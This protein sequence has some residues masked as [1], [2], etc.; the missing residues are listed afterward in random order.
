[1]LFQGRHLTGSCDVPTSAKICKK[2]KFSKAH[3]IVCHSKDNLILNK[4]FHRTMTWKLPVFEIWDVKH[5]IMTSSISRGEISFSK[6]YLLVYCLIGNLILN[7]FGITTVVSKR[8]IFEIWSAKHS[9]MMSSIS[10]GNNSLSKMYFL[11]Y[12]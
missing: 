10:R 6:I 1:M 11:V 7:N 8:P 2:L 12:C 9:N 3:H 4:F 5:L